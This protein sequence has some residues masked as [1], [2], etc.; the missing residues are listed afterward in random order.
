[1]TGRKVEEQQSQVLNCGKIPYLSRSGGKC[2]MAIRLCKDGILTC[3]AHFDG[4]WLGRVRYRAEPTRNT[5]HFRHAVTK[6]HSLLALQAP[7]MF[8]CE[9]VPRLCK[10]SLNL[11]VL[12]LHAILHHFIHPAFTQ[13]PAGYQRSCISHFRS[14]SY[15]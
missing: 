3:W 9:G 2:K 1:M 8:F 10:A 6:M 4:H 13:V 12:L 5:S 15:V 11:V 14:V 7:Q